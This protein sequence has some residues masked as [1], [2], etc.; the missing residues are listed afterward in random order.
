ME[1]PDSYFEDEV[2]DGFYV[3]GMMKRS[4]AA[5][6]EVLDAVSKVCEKHQIT[7]FAEWGTLLGAVRHE[8]MVPWDDDIDICMKRADYEKFLKVAGE[9]LPEG[10]GI[11]SYRTHDTDNLVTKVTGYPDLLL[12]EKDLP[13]FHGYPYIQSID[14]FALDFLPKKKEGQE[15]MWELV[16][17]VAQLNY[18]EAHDDMEAD[19]VQIA[20]RSVEQLCEVTFDRS[21]PMN[22]QLTW[23]MEATAARFSEK[24]CD[25]VTILGYYMNSKAYRFPKSYYAGIVMM[26]FEC[27]K[28]AIP[29]EYEALLKKK[30]GRYMRP[31]RMFD[32]HAYPSYEIIH[33]TVREQMGIEP[34]QY[35]FS[36][37]EMEEAAKRLPK[38]TLQSRVRGFLSLFHEAH[39]EVRNMIE[40]GDIPSV[41]G[42]LGECQNVAIEIGTMIEEERGE[43]HPT[44]GVLERYCEEIFQLHQILNGED[45]PGAGEEILLHVEGL[46]VFEE[47]LAESIENDLKERKEVVF[48]PYKTSLWGAMESVWQAAVE[49]E[50]TDVYVIPAPYYYKDD[51]GK[52]KKDEPHY[53]TDY[54]EGV[55]ITSYEEYNFEVH[56]PDVVVIQWPYDEYS[57]G[58]TVHPFFYA[59]NLK[60]YTDN[61]VYIPPF[62]MDEIK[63]KDE[64][65]RATLKYFCNMPGVVHAD[66]VV[67]QSE[68]MKEVYVEL[69]TKFAG[70]ETKEMWENKISGLGSPEQDQQKENLSADKVS[71]MIPEEWKK[72]IYRGDGSRK[73]IILYVTSASVLYSGGER[74]VDKIEEVFDT[75]EEVKEEVVLWWMPDLKA[76]EMLRKTKPAVWQ[77]YRDLVQEYKQAGWGIYDDSADP[78]RAVR[79]CDAYYGDGSSAAN[80]CW[81]QNKPVMLQNP[82][83]KN[84]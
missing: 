22:R 60:K 66:R 75:F 67:V 23:A 56:H 58:S 2:R 11:I 51:F 83:I 32:T 54:P 30:Y 35:K 74:V 7:Y 42:I 81:V 68:Q 28:I 70:E 34:F 31:V 38:E 24:D 62:L 71:G 1:F 43:G 82:A 47:H 20:L 41:T 3:P 33:Q 26:P 17:T 46:R 5:K 69:L 27:T 77:K 52:I 40:Q 12:Q 57:Y 49:D 25:E 29:M 76:R 36:K 6:I 44:V 65:G 14:I 64:R 4:W 53:E 19:D 37:T 16:N 84:M 61:L 55:E 18:R 9:E 8:G 79:F 15:A 73:K 10:Y 39:K 63:E 72:K 50:E 13:R 48:V 45:V 59:K 78:E 21:R 80:M